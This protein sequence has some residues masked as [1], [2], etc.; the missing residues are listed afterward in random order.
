[1]AT[2]D[3]NI[4]KMLYTIEDYLEDDQLVIS[5]DGLSRLI[6]GGLH[7]A[8]FRHESNTANSLSQQISRL[9]QDA[10]NAGENL[11][12]IAG[13]KAAA[14]LIHKHTDA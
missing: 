7:D 1:M 13:L 10:A 4:S 9:A 2:R 11:D 3:K 12:Y 8:G 6:A 5:G 14:K